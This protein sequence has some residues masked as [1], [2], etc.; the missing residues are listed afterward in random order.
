MAHPPV[1]ESRLRFHDAALDL[2][3]EEGFAGLKLARLCRRVGVTTGAFYHVFDSWSAFTEELLEH[4]Y[5]ERTAEVAERCAA[6]TDPGARLD[7]VL[8]EALALR[9]R[10]ESAIRTWAGVDPRVRTVQ[11]RADRERIALVEDALLALTGDDAVAHRL[12]RASLYV[13]VGYEQVTGEPDPEALFWALGH[14]R[15]VA[16]AEARGARRS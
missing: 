12:A 6:V 16:D 2:L 15:E 4:W 8:T 13:L 9:H 14:L 1:P 5:R 7:L 3:A 10:A 11:E